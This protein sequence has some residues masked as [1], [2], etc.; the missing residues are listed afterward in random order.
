VRETLRQENARVYSEMYE[1]GIEPFR[2]TWKSITAFIV[3]GVIGLTSMFAAFALV[4]GLPV[5]AV[6]EFFKHLAG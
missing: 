3:G 1:E 4:I 5:H 2:G 6:G